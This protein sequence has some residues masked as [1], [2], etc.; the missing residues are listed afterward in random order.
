MVRVQCGVVQC[1]AVGGC[2]MLLSCLYGCAVRA[3]EGAMPREVQEVLWG[4]QCGHGRV[5]CSTSDLQCCRDTE[6][7]AVPR[8]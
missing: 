1:S 5:Q 4:L 7:S 3:P 6:H 8:G 2:T